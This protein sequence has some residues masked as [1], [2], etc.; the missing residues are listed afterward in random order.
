MAYAF[1]S[2]T[3]AFYILFFTIPLFFSIYLSF[4][5]WGG[6]DLGDIKWVGLNNYQK[7]F[8]GETDFFHPILTNTLYFAFGTVAISFIC[9]LAVAYTIS[10]LKHEGF[11]RTL[12]FLPSVTTVVAVGNVW[13]YMYD[14]TSGLINDIIGKLGYH[15]IPFM[16]RPDIALS[17]LIIVGGWLGIG[18]S[19]L[20][21]TAGLK[22][23]P[24]DLY[25]AA[26]MEGAGLGKTFMTITLPLLKPSIL[27][28]LITSFI[29]G[30]QS[31]T[32]ILVMT[33]TGG[34]GNSTNVG[35]LAMY[36]QAF[37]FGNW[38]MACA[39]AVLLFVVIFIITM[40]QLFA[41]KKGGVEGYQ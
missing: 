17:A 19:M 18:S 16:D 6:F 4:T 31:F 35:G 2:P 10:R 15:P 25:E 3:F 8:S 40:I 21:L 36:N 33:K 24:E 38:G 13:S 26:D 27:F 28:V 29:G 12:Y 37:S 5:E 7:L 39:M 41:F 22:A 14:P 30:L 11:W 20:I 23:I 9:A 32:L 34:P 1:L